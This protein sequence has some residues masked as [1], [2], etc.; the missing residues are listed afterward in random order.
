MYTRYISTQ[1]MEGQPWNIQWCQGEER[2]I[3]AETF[4]HNKVVIII[5]IS[6][7]VTWKTGYTKQNLQISMN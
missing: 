4:A 5:I 2:P 7:G 3:V 1:N 6:T